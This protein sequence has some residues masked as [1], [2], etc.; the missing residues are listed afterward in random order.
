[1]RAGEEVTGP[2]EEFLGTG[3]AVRKLVGRLVG[4]MED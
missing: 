3:K 2:Q 4:G 1:M